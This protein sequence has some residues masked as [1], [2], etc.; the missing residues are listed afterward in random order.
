M[1]LPILEYEC[2]IWDP[3]TT[4]DIDNI[5]KIQRRA[6]RFILNDYSWNTCVTQLLQKLNLQLPSLKSH[7]T[8]QK[9]IM[10]YKIAYSLA[11]NPSSHL[12]PNTSQTCHHQYCFRLAALF[13]NKCSSLFFFPS[14]ITIWNNLSSHIINS[15]FLDILKKNLFNCI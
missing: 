9:A 13:M 12:I 14:A 3:S 10:I 15:N 6:D 11:C 8:C 5:E 4:K 7:R 2:S 1:V